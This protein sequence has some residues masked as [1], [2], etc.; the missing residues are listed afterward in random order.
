MKKVLGKLI[1]VLTVVIFVLNFC[2]TPPSY[3]GWLE[4]LLMSVI[5][6]FTW[7][8]RAI[9]MGIAAGINALTAALAY[10][11]GA[12]DGNTTTM[13]LTP[14][15]ILFNKIQIFDINIF[16]IA[17]SGIEAQSVV[18]QI[19]VGVAGWYYAL[20]SIA[21]AILLCMLIYVGIRMAISTIATDKA[22][23]KKMLVDW[24]ASMALLF[25]LHYIM[26]FTIAVNNAII[27]ALS[28]GIDSEVIEKTYQ[29]ISG[30][31]F[32]AFDPNSIAATVVYC[33]IVWQTLGLVFVYFNR[34]LKL[35]FLTIIAPLVTIT[36]SID[37]MGDGKAQ[38]LG[39]WLKEYVYTILIQ[40]FH[41]VV[42]MTLIDMGF[43]LISDSEG[44]TPDK[45]LAASVISILCIRFTKDAEQLVRKIFA[46]KDDGSTGINTGLAF[47]AAGL[48]QAKNIGK[49]ARAGVNG[50][51]NFKRTGVDSMRAMGKGLGRVAMGAH[52]TALALGKQLNK[53]N[54]NTWAD[55]KSEA[56]AQIN[57]NKAKKIEEKTSG[58]FNAKADENF[59][60][61]VESLRAAN[62]QMGLREAQ[63][64]VRL[65]NARAVRR[66]EKANSKKRKTDKKSNGA[67]KVTGF[68]RT[69][70]K[71]KDIK[72][73]STVIQG[74][75]SMAKGYVG[76]GIGLS[77]GS[78]LYGTGKDV[79]TALA[80]NAAV[81]KGTKEF[82][83]GSRGTLRRGVKDNFRGMGI[84]SQEAALRALPQIL[85]VH[86]DPDAA[87]E[88][89]DSIMKE[90][91]KA[92]QEAGIEGKYST[93]IKNSIQAAV[94][95]DPAHTGN[96]IQYSLSRIG[97]VGQS[98]Y[99]ANDGK[100]KD[101]TEKLADHFNAAEIYKS[102]QTAAEFGIKPDTFA[103]DVVS[104]F[105]VVKDGV[106]NEHDLNP[107]EVVTA[108]ENVEGKGDNIPT[109]KEYEEAMAEINDEV[110]GYDD[111]ELVEL[112]KQYE[113]KK[114]DLEK[115]LAEEKSKLA[116]PTQKTDAIKEIEEQIK[117]I[118]REQA[119]VMFAALADVTR[120]Q[121]LI[122]Q[123]LMA[124][125]EAEYQSIIEKLHAEFDAL[126]NTNKNKAALIE[127][128]INML[129]NNHEI[130]TKRFES[131]P[132]TNYESR[133]NG[134]IKVDRNGVMKTDRNGKIKT[135][136]RREA[137]D[138]TDTY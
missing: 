42:Y 126:N 132:A 108:T 95:A 131:M 70:N 46:F 13:F 15:D 88:E 68:R 7:P 27:N 22:M 80:T 101:V 58:K 122:E 77:V 124:K 56:R 71:F 64:K 8:I 81:F 123:E 119:Q 16:N 60:K 39:N 130:M 115:E 38:A 11:E 135:T 111:D 44:A 1:I 90:L 120:D 63:S 24:C 107:E 133:S 118:E 17:T 59:A 102:F 76:L 69:L 25:L 127:S 19:R 86:S 3:A 9:A 33:M 35:C 37:K 50:I 43:K 134:R 66:K 62:P 112:D 45:V 110:R 97:G 2:M 105:D 73:N 57:E 20:R 89:L 10:I 85:G 117:T 79:A 98:A 82:M 78:G 84:K 96:A 100:I 116:D 92:L 136:K 30:I 138:E 18:N 23:Y 109:P 54:Q 103:A 34:W 53:D 36:Y 72:D 29:L 49:S 75:G 41:C 91:E 14:F 28:T 104:T 6:L 32:S 114:I 26:I 125:Y 61:Q 99:T 21:A 48:M 106:V 5:G 55:N 83:Q 40:P 4:D 74:L 67:K 65:D 113:L 12:T 51:R 52:A 129:D 137:F 93:S 87:K 121:T 94:K 47:A 128:Q 31:A